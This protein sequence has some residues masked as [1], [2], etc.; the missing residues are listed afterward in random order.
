M[1]INYYSLGDEVPTENYTLQT[2]LFFVN[3]GV[4]IEGLIRREFT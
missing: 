3:F 4:M 2:K 1:K